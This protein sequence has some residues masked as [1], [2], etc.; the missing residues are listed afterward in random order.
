[1]A[2]TDVSGLVTPVYTATL[3][4]TTDGSTLTQADLTNTVVS[5]GNRI[6]FVRDLV[7]DATDTPEVFARINEDFLDAVVESQ[8]I[9][10]TI[11][12]TVIQSGA[13]AGGLAISHVAGTA[14]NP[15]GLACSCPGTLGDAS[16][17]FFVGPGATSTPFSFASFSEFTVVMKIATDSSTLLTPSVRIG[18]ASNAGFN[19]GGNESL[20]LMYGPAF[21]SN[22]MLLR[23]KAAAQTATVLAPMVLGEHITARFKKDPVSGDVGVY[24]DGALITTVSA[25]NMPTGGCTFGAIQSISTVEGAT[26]ITPVY[27]F[28]GARFIAGNRSGV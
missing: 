6:E 10:G 8:T 11:P 9:Y 24:I 21:G 16:H 14:K 1:M 4:V 5:L 12:W 7:P 17:A 15:G 22:W 26:V 20:G 28:I 19:N 18:L 27:D 3:P 2:T 25:A 23:R 13:G